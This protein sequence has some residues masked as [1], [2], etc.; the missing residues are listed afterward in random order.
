MHAA[1]AAVTANIR[2]RDSTVRGIITATALTTAVMLRANTQ[3]RDVSFIRC[4]GNSVVSDGNTG[5]FESKT[6]VLC[7][8]DALVCGDGNILVC[9]G[10]I[11]ESEDCAIACDGISVALSDDPIMLK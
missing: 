2:H 9:D 7:D 3:S 11:V 8:S 4:R 1:Q 10:N 5:V 6:I